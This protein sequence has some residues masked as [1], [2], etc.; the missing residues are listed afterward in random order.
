MEGWTS[1]VV[2]C[3]I[4]LYCCAA[5]YSTYKKKFRSWPWWRYVVWMIGILCI[6]I[7]ID[8]PIAER[9][10]SEFEAHM[11]THLL[12]GMLAPLL[13]VLSSPITLLFRTLPVKQGRAL[14]KIIK[15]R[16]V[17]VV[18]HPIT[19]VILNMGGLWLLYRTDLYQAMHH[20]TLLHVIIH[21]HFFAAG[22]LFTASMLYF[23][24]V[25]HR[26]S[27]QYRTCVFFIFLTMHGILSKT[28]YAYPPEGIELY[29]AETGAMIMYYG[30]DL[31]DAVM[32]IILFSQ[33]Y[34]SLKTKQIILV[35]R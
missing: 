10:N 4:S 27:F 20:S 22:Y 15:S 18:S 32:I 23:E 17:R 29:S 11:V 28:I 31:I 30:G 9:A 3:I 19:A 26:F 6:A 5:Y 24:P 21:F 35:Q 2:I 14:S 8:G 34:R 16:Y 7:S 25:P 1:I 33:W 13:L 12:L